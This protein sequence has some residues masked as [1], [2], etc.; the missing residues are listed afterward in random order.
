MAVHKVIYSW[1]RLSPK[2]RR[3]FIL[4]TKGLY[5]RYKL[6]QKVLSVF[7]DFQD[8]ELA[9]V[10]TKTLLH[11]L[12]QSTPTIQCTNKNLLNTLSDLNN[13]LHE[14]L[15]L[16]YIK[17][18]EQAVEYDILRLKALARHRLSKEF[19]RIEKKVNSKLEQIE[20]HNTYYYQR[21][22]DLRQVQLSAPWSEQLNNDFATPTDELLE[23]LES[24]YMNFKLKL[25]VEMINRNKILNE[26]HSVEGLEELRIK[27][28]KIDKIIT[29]IHFLCL[30][31]VEE[32]Q[33]KDFGALYDVFIKEKALPVQNQA[34]IMQVLLN[35][36]FR[37]RRE[38]DKRDEFTKKSLYI[39]KLSLKKGLLTYG[40]YMYHGFFQN[41]V[42][43]ACIQKDYDYAESFITKWKGYLTEE[44][45]GVEQFALATLY[46]SKGQYADIQML[47]NNFEYKS[48]F[49]EIDCRI[50]QLQA[51]YEL[52]WNSKVLMTKIESYL[53]LVRRKGKI[54]KSKQIRCLQ[55]GQCLFF[56]VSYQCGEADM[57]SFLEEKTH[58]ARKEWL[59]EKAIENDKEG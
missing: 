25:G 51:Q 30:N 4:F 59:L 28:Q 57:L 50:I 16:T 17:R 52:G 15:V 44:K 54:N 43:L 27:A 31:I 7:N 56:L 14:Y 29:K 18:P 40:G 6:A 21:M 53:K 10:S 48:V 5:G 24:Y 8:D 58:S 32:W 26:T 37:K 19:S 20:Y 33:Q 12:V 9:N 34:D 46:Y 47:L 23:Y 3:D 2:H 45:K 11:S 38:P 1:I 49:N 55:F 39:L 13:W 35:Y 41:M 42:I 36:C 22:I